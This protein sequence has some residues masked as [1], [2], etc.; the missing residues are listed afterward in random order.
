[1]EEGEETAVAGDVARDREGEGNPPGF[2]PP[3]AS[4]CPPAPSLAEPAGSQPTQKSGK[5]ACRWRPA[6]KTKQDGEGRECS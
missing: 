3:P 1:M 4:D 5:G 2:S 6:R